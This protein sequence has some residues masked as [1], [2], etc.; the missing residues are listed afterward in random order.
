[1]KSGTFCTY[2]TVVVVVIVKQEQED[3]AM[4]F[5]DWG[6]GATNPLHPLYQSILRIAAGNN[7]TTLSGRIV[8]M[9]TN[10]MV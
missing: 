2:L 3:L 9:M 10:K 4:V 7:L 6:L 5:I 1:V 8:N